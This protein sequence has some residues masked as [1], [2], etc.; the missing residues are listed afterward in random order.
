MTV[1]VFMPEGTEAEVCA[2]IA[3]R[4]AFG[5]NKYGMIVAE[6][7]SSLRA[8]LL[9]HAY[10]ETLDKAVY[11]KRAIAEIDAQQARQAGKPE[12]WHACGNVG[13]EASE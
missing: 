8:R 2:D 13:M 10:E 11:L 1:G 12:G 4:Q 5:K 6:N 3:R 9:H 7:P